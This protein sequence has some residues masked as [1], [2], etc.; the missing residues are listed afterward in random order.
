MNKTS[1]IIGIIGSL[2]AV[3]L[4]CIYL[5]RTPVMQT[6]HSSVIS[7][8]TTQAPTSTISQT[9]T[10]TADNHPGMKLYQNKE[11]GFEFWYP[12]GWE[13]QENIFGSLFSKFNLTVLK[14]N[15]Q[16]T[17]QFGSINIVTHDFFENYL[18]NMRVIK[19]EET[20]TVVNYISGKQFRYIS[21][22]VPVI[23]I[24]FPLK[25]YE[26]LFGIESKYEKELKS[27]ISTFKFIR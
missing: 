12:E 8:S 21:E 15:G 16:Y 20:D 11:F 27:I 17:N 7:S 24:V 2:I 3:I 13:W 5:L 23:D 25:E 4:I 22:S 26:V 1:K 14:I 10:T 9:S 18:F 6:N 19:A